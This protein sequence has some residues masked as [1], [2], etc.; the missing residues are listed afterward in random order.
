VN[1]TFTEDR[2]QQGYEAM[3]IGEYSPTFRRSFVS[4]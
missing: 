1:N 2:R 4:I 3:S